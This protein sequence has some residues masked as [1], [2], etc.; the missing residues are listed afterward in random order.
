MKDEPTTLPIGAHTFED[1]LLQWADVLETDVRHASLRRR[2]TVQMD[3]DQLASIARHLR[4]AS[5]L[6][7]QANT[8][9]P[10]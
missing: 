1:G 8:E 5:R 9:V 2:D 4:G 7:E 3:V 10:R 6:L